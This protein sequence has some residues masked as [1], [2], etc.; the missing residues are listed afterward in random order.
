M[1]IIKQNADPLAVG[2]IV[3]IAGHILETWIG[4][5]LIAL[6][7]CGAVYYLLFSEDS[8]GEYYLLAN[9]LN[10]AVRWILLFVLS[11]LILWGI[12]FPH[13]NPFDSPPLQFDIVNPVVHPD[14]AIIIRSHDISHEEVPTL[15]VEFDGI[16]FSD[17]ANPNAS[18][19]N[20]HWS[21][22]PKKQ[23][24][25]S[26]Y[27]ISEGTHYLRIGVNGNLRPCFEKGTS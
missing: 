14:S 23:P 10:R 22:S 9:L 8:T 7:I 21:F 3:A 2:L 4:D 12:A 13:F 15:D 11:P 5:F 20:H 1:Q 25:Y 26:E 27:L 24:T 18:Q 19:G 17:G 16:P 6:V